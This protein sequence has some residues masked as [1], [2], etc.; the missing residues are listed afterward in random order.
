MFY[1]KYE[2][3]DYRPEFKDQIIDLTKII[4]GEDENKNRTYFEWKFEQSPYFKEIIGAIGLYKGKAIAFNGLTVLKWYIDNRK[5][6]FYTIG[7]TGAC[8]QMNHQR[9]GLHTAMVEYI[10]KK[11]KTSKFKLITGF[12]PNPASTAFALKTGWEIFATRKYLRKYDYLQM[13]KREIL[14]RVKAQS[15][16]LKKVLGKYGSIEVTQNVKPIVMVNLIEKIPEHKNGI[17]LYRDLGF[18]Q[19]RFLKPN[20]NYLFY[21]LWDK[22]KRLKGYFVVKYYCRS[23]AGK[24]IDYAYLDIKYFQKILTFLIKYKHFTY[25][26]LL[27]VNL[28]KVLRN[29][30]HNFGF[31]HRDLVIKLITK[32]RKNRKE[33][34]YVVKPLKDKSREDYWFID[35]L[36]IRKAENWK[37]T[38]ICSEDV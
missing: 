28:D 5:N 14:T 10:M 24:I 33:L 4:W 19:W 2:I 37:F 20:V 7:N 15:D 21:Y 22:D 16:K 12:S 18:M 9:K 30:I 6:I 34:C 23:G 38:E 13:G 29:V 27:D 25:I 31:H 8:T 11:H 17:C 32:K 3:I 1:K 36:D 35:N 26:F